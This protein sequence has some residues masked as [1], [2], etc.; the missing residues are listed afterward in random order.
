MCTSYKVASGETDDN[1]RFDLNVTIDTTFFHDYFLSVR[2]PIDTNYITVSGA[3]GVNY[4]EVRFDAFHSNELQN[5]KF[6]FYPKTYLTITLHRTLSD[7]FNYFSV[8][9]N[10][11][12]EF[13]YADYIITGPQYANDTTFRVTT[14]ADIYTRIVWRKTVVAGQSNEQIDSLICTRNGTNVFDIN[15]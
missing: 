6:E 13:D 9:H 4:N 1:G 2:V 8:N 14:S 7:S 10:F 5:L 12:N 11:T 3:G 15:Y